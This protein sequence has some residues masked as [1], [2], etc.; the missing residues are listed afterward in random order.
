MPFNQF[1]LQKRFTANRRCA[2]TNELQNNQTQTQTKK[3]RSKNAYA[4]AIS[5]SFARTQ[6]IWMCT[7]SLCEHVCMRVCAFLQIFLF[8]SSFFLAPVIR[9]FFSAETVSSLFHRGLQS[10]RNKEM[11]YN[12]NLQSSCLLSL[13]GIE[14]YVYAVR[15]NEL[16]FKKNC[17]FHQRI[18][19]GRQKI[20]MA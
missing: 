19:A 13:I 10:N 17:V 18:T 8:S 11:D 1:K 5:F 7:Q 9:I 14:V 12:Y 2:H 20:S 16:L 6:R 15:K 4:S 3:Q